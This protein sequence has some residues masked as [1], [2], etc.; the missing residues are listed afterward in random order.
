MFY[1]EREG[2]VYFVKCLYTAVGDHYNGH[3]PP[4]SRSSQMVPGIFVKGL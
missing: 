4:W 2:G 3:Q 1:R